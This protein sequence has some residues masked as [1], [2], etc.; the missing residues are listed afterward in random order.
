MADL[1]PDWTGRILNQRM[2]ATSDFSPLADRGSDREFSR[3][4]AIA[5]SYRLPVS[6]KKPFPDDDLSV[7]D[8]INAHGDIGGCRNCRDLKQSLLR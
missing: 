2:D 4:V 8:D 7:V 5:Q 3:I 6:Q 1:A